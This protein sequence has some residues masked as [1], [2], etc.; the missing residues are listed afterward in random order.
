MVWSSSCLGSDVFVWALK[1]YHKINY[2]GGF[3]EIWIYLLLGFEIF[4]IYIIYDPAT[5]GPH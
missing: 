1:K 5:R 4:V 3:M 2:F